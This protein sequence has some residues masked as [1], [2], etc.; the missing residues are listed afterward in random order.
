MIN[1]YFTLSL[2]KIRQNKLRLISKKKKNVDLC[3]FNIFFCSKND[4]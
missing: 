1:R 2:N 3:I 4:L